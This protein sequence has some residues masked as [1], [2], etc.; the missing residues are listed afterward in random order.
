MR[1]TQVNPIDPNP[2]IAARVVFPQSGHSR[3]EKTA[4]FPYFSTFSQ[5]TTLKNVLTAYR[6]PIYQIKAQDMLLKIQKKLFRF[7]K[8]VGLG[9][10]LTLKVCSKGQGNFE[11][12]LGNP[13]EIR[14][15]GCRT[16]GV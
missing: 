12:I 14:H 9:T 2:A 11:G 6:V 3:L 4:V 16:S 7:D 10:T 5:K 1:T 13:G 15:I 8:Y